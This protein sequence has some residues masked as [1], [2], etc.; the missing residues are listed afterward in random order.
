MRGEI[1]DIRWLV[2]GWHVRLGR[3]YKKFDDPETMSAW[4]RKVYDQAK[5]PVKREKFR[6]DIQH[7]INLDNAA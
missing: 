1:L 3:A 5:D 4:F 2:D 7:I 6:R